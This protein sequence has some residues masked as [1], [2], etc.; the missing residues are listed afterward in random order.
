MNPDAYIQNRQANIIIITHICVL[1]SRYDG[2][3]GACS[4]E[5]AVTIR[6]ENNEVVEDGET[7]SAA[8]A[9][10][11]VTADDDGGVG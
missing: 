6:N 5:K 4:F 11:A 1:P 3:R 9:C 2:L 8:R 10:D 7:T